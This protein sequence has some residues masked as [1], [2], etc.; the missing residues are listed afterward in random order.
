[1]ALGEW[2]LARE[3]FWEGAEKILDA[4]GV[5][6]RDAGVRV[7]GEGGDSGEDVE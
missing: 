4:W 5:G 3:G 7:V 1:M 6:R 2:G